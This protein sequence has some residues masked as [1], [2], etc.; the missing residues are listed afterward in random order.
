VIALA[1]FEQLLGLESVSSD[2][3]APATRA[4]LSTPGGGTVELGAAVYE[5]FELD[6]GATLACQLVGEN[7]LAHQAPLS[8]ADCRTMQLYC[9]T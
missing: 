1:G 4:S 5:K 2:A 9:P 7:S 8:E 3:G 6:L